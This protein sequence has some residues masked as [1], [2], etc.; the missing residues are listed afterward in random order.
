M[1]ESLESEDALFR[2]LYDEGLKDSQKRRDQAAK[3]P[4]F[5]TKV[6]V[7]ERTDKISNFQFF[8]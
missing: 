8:P 5:Y 7:L 3:I 4:K 2:K 6:M 1:T